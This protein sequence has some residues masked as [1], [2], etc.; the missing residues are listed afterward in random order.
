MKHA[1]TKSKIKTVL[2]QKSGNNND[3]KAVK[4]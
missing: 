2:T 4:T 3:R 1:S